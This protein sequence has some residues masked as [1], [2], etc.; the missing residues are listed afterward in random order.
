MLS[1]KYWS[2]YYW[3]IIIYQP[4]SFTRHWWKPNSLDQQ[5]KMFFGLTQ[6]LVKSK[7]KKTYSSIYLLWWKH[8]LLYGL[9]CVPS[10]TITSM[11]R[12]GKILYNLSHICF[13]DCT[14]WTCRPLTWPGEVICRIACQEVIGSTIVSFNNGSTYNSSVV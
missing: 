4:F 6:C 3:N 8:S 12:Q 7:T 5:R 14:S 10:I 9:A 11:V 1:A 2:K 13:T